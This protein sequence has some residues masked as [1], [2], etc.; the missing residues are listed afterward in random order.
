[1]TDQDKE[2][3]KTS[4]ESG[5]KYGYPECCIDEFIRQYPSLIKN[6]KPSNLDVLRYKMGL[7]NGEFKGFIPCLKHATQILKKEIE[8]NS[9]ID[10]EKRIEK[11]PFPNGWT[12]K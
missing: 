7:V 5:R 1:M 9:L 6:K 2:F 12:Y 3:I 10:L 11:T 4:I 8:L